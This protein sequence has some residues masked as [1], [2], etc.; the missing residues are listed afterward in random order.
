[1]IVLDDD[2]AVMNFVVV[3]GCIAVGV[4]ILPITLQP[5]FLALS[6]KWMESRV[7]FDKFFPSWLANLSFC[8]LVKDLATLRMR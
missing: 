5:E 8:I 4:L 2:V 1:M 7:C 6:E 3:V